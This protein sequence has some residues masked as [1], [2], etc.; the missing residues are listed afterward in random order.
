MSCR[1]LLCLHGVLKVVE[2]GTYAV[3]WSTVEVNVAIVC[4]SLL[5]MKPLFAKWV[6]AMVSEQPMSASEDKRVLR[7]LTGLALLEG[8]LLECKEDDRE[9]RRRDTGVAGLGRDR[10]NEGSEVLVRI[11]GSRSLDLSISRSKSTTSLQ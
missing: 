10:G 5:V 3:L 9:P 7:C 4:A 6:P 1:S 8:G 2:S 11:G